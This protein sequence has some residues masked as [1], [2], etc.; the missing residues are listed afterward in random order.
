MALFAQKMNERIFAPVYFV[1]FSGNIPQ[2]S[3]RSDF[4]KENG[5]QLGKLLEKVIYRLNGVVE[6][7]GDV[8][9]EQVGI[10]DAGA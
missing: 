6:Q 10:L 7:L 4:I 9:L 1:Y 2:V 3:F 8:A 5:H